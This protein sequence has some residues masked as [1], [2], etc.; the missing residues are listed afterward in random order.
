MEVTFVELEILQILVELATAAWIF[1][2]VQF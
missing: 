1:R 2:P